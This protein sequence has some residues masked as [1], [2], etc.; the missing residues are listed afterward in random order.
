M[1][2]RTNNA[3]DPANAEKPK[4]DEE[5]LVTEI[6]KTEET[7]TVI[8]MVCVTDRDAAELELSGKETVVGKNDIE[9]N[10]K[11]KLEN[12]HDALLGLIGGKIIG[13]VTPREPTD[14]LFNAGALGLYIELET[15]QGKPEK[16]VAW[17][18]QAP[19]RADAGY[20][21]IEESR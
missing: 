6:G 7:K 12:Q 2:P 21:E 19:D 15:L 11:A 4:T 20:L 14:P 8:R 18:M 9:A 13:L 3:A 10:T 5:T 17:I 16:V 1:A